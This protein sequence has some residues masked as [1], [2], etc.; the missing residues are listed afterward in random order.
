[1][2]RL[3]QSGL[4]LIEIM[5]ALA[6][7][8]VLSALAIPLYQGFIVEGRISTAIKDIRQAELIFDNLALEG[9][10]NALDGDDTSVRGLYLRNGELELG[11][12]SST[13][14]GAEPWLDPWDRIYRYQRAAT[15]SGVRT[16]SGGNVSNDAN[17]SMAP[18]SYDL[19]SQGPD[20]GDASD[21]VMRGCNGEYAGTAGGHSC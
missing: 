19:F 12:P 14:V 1:M 13:P 15:N 17:N 5:I 9:D 7:L 16:D 11:D 18:Q 2:T 21:D 4:T 6:I 10:L 20:T 3:R 8:A